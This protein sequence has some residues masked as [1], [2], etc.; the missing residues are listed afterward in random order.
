MVLFLCPPYA[1]MIRRRA[2]LP[3]NL[4]EIQYTVSVILFQLEVQ[5]GMKI[6]SKR[7]WF[8]YNLFKDTLSS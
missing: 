7:L 3:F 6:I 8:V 1:L 2:T 5:H 4:H